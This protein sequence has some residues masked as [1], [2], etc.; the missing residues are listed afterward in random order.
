MTP[1][2]ARAAQAAGAILVDTRPI[3]QRAAHGE[4]PGAIVIERNVLEWRLDPS[5]SHAIDAARS[6]QPI[7]LYCQEGYSTSLAVVSLL[8]CGLTDVSD[9]EGGFDAWKAAG[10]PTTDATQ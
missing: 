3:A 1:E 8:D 2:A 10:L 6:G 5:S 7:V 9:L 4:I